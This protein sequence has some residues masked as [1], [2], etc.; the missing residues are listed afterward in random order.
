MDYPDLITQREFALEEEF[1]DGDH[2]WV[3]SVHVEYVNP[4]DGLKSESNYSVSDVF[5]SLSDAQIVYDHLDKNGWIAITP[6][7]EGSIALIEYQ[8]VRSTLLSIGEG[9]KS[10]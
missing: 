4:R 2:V 6:R 8:K 9:G 10:E 7:P 3:L 5:Y 1:K